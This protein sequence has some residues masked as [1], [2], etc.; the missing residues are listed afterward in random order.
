VF[1]LINGPIHLNSILPLIERTRMAIDLFGNSFRSPMSL[2]KL[3]G[4]VFQHCISRR[5][6]GIEGVQ[7]G[8]CSLCLLHN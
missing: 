6:H 1:R 5:G 3:R 8:L 4:L 7:Q 2:N